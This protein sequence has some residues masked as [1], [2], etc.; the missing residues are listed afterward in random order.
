MTTSDTPLATLLEAAH[1]AADAAASITLAGFRAGLRVEDKAAGTGAHIDPVTRADRD[2]EAAIRDVLATR[3]PGIAFVG[4]ESAASAP[5]E[6]PDVGDAGDGTRRR[7]VVDPIDGTRAYIAGIPVWGTLVAL[8]DERGPV[9][10]LL[11]QPY[12]GERFVGHAGG[13]TLVTRHGT[14]ELRTRAGRGLA[15]AVLCAT[16]PEMFAAGAETEAF[17]RVAARAMTVRWGT[18]CYG[19]AMLAAGCVDAVVEAGLSAWDTEALIP[20]ILGAG[21]IVTDWRGGPAAGSSTVVAAG[22]AS[23]HAEILHALRDV[24][25]SPRRR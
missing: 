10:G 18:D 23:L 13:S 22:S 8:S 21:G 24:P 5:A 7:W 1:A 14:R 25:A 20:L 17:A 11:D 15:E 3:C 12:V 19:Y 9:F 2:A 6:A 4:E 16:A